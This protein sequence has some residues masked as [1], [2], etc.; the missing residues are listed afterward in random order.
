MEP[1]EVGA[2]GVGFHSTCA[3][4]SKMHGTI[5]YYSHAL[6]VLHVCICLWIYMYFSWRPGAKL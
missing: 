1:P 4:M 2:I 3:C 6:A 5:F